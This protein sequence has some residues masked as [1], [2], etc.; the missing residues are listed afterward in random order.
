MNIT[1]DTLISI[2]GIMSCLYFMV[3]LIKV[4]VDS[5]Y[6]KDTDDKNL[7]YILMLSSW[8]NVSLLYFTLLIVRYII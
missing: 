1:I 6:E 4:S 7:H 5:F 3:F 8:F 2:T